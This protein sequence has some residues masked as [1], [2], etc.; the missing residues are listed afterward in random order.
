MSENLLNSSVTKA[1]AREGIEIDQEYRAIPS[2]SAA[3]LGLAI[4]RVWTK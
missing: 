2:R 1:E 3:I 4:T